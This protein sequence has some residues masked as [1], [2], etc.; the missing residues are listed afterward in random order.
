MTRQECLDAVKECVMKDRNAS[1]GEPE[2]NFKN[3]ADYWGTYLA[4]IG[5]IGRSDRIRPM[6]VAAMM[7]LVK[8][9]R[10]ATSPQ[11]KDN[12]VDGAGYMVCGV[13]VAT[14]PNV[15]LKGKKTNIG[16]GE[17]V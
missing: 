5:L 9:A 11:N 14:E 8:L 4:S 10:L 17:C 12:W 13:E 7:T 6:D 3:I 1:Y 15:T 2:D 16:K